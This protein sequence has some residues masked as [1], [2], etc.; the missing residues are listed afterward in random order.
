LSSNIP[1]W[2]PQEIRKVSTSLMT[3]AQKMSTIANIRVVCI[4]SLKNHAKKIHERSRD[5]QKILHKV[6]ISLK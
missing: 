1:R 5:C 3:Y 2:C 4:I 6:N